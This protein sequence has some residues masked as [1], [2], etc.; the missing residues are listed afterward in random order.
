M[1]IETTKIIGNVVCS[2][3]NL[4]EGRRGKELLFFNVIFVIALIKVDMKFKTN[5]MTFIRGNLDK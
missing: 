3:E 4:E 2:R 5:G 1:E